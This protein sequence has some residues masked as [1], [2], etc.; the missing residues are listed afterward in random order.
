MSD[1]LTLLGSGLLQAFEP[2]N[3][4]MIFIGCLAGLFIGA[5]PGLGSVNG[6][7]ILLPITF[8]VPAD[9]CDNLPRGTLLRRDVWWRD[10]VDHA[11]YSRGVDGSGHG[12]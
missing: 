10:L 12:I 1:I 2:L 7:A 5:M 3:L 9:G 4:F 6:V 8:L 11:W